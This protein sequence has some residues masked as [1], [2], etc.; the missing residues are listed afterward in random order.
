[1]DDSLS[2]STDESSNFLDFLDKGLEYEQNNTFSLSEISKEIK[3]D[4]LLT[5][6]YTSGT[7]GNPKGVMLTHKN[8][9]SN[10]VA[11]INMAD[12]QSL[13]NHTFLSFL[14]LSHVLERMGGHFTSFALGATRL[15]C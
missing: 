2:E 6:I 12:L 1:M 3:E 9:I 5:M 10:V 14:P 8:L 4:D 15:L 7:T 11:T 13:D